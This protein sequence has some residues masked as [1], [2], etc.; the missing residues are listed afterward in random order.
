[1]NKFNKIRVLCICTGHKDSITV[2]F[3]A[4]LLVLLLYLVFYQIFPTLDQAG[5]LSTTSQEHLLTKV[6]NSSQFLTYESKFYKMSYVEQFSTTGPIKEIQ[7]WRVGSKQMHRNKC[8]AFEVSVIGL[9][10]NY[11]FRD[12]KVSCPNWDSYKSLQKSKHQSWLYR[13]NTGLWKIMK[14][15]FAPRFLL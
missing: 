13:K 3:C 11:S 5:R 15:T 10:S 12:P 14:S 1:M 4:M 6:R 2:F 7:D 8:R 9:G